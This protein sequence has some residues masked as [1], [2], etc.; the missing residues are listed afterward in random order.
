[1]KP[2]PHAMFLATLIVVAAVVWAGLV[3]ALVRVERTVRARGWHAGGD[4]TTL[5]LSCPVLQLLPV[6]RC[7]ANN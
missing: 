4:A 2:N 6:L 5:G 7:V 1:M 3:A